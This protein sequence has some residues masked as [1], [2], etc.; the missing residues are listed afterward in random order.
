MP[1]ISF[2]L[3]SPH[4]RL[5]VFNACVVADI[6]LG[7]SSNSCRLL[8]SA[9]TYDYVQISLYAYLIAAYIPIAEARGIT[10]LF[11][12][13]NMLN[14]TSTELVKCRREPYK[15]L[16]LAFIKGLKSKSKLSRRNIEKRIH[17]LEQEE[18]Y[19]ECVGVVIYFLRREL[20]RYD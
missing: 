7:Y 20:T 2:F 5:A 17:E 6:A 4:S 12:N 14:D 9:K 1:S 13:G 8:H 3:L 19:R 18:P 16:F 10:P 15:N 11:D